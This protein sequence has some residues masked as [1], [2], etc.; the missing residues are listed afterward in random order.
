M[1]PIFYQL[2]LFRHNK[3]LNSIIKLDEKNLYFNNIELKK[4]FNLEFNS[5]LKIN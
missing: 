3:D 1:I 2:K 4:K 5:L